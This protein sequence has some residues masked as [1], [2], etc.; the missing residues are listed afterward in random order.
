MAAGHTICWCHG[1]IWRPARAKISM[2]LLDCGQASR[3]VS[4][5]GD[6]ADMIMILKT[7]INYFPSILFTSDTFCT[8]SSAAIFI[9]NRKLWRFS[10]EWC[11]HSAFP[12]FYKPDTVSIHVDLLDY[13][14]TV[15]YRAFL[16]DH[17]QYI[18]IPYIWRRWSDRSWWI[19][20]LYK[21][22]GI[23]PSQFGDEYHSAGAA[24][25][26]G[27]QSWKRCSMAGW[28]SDIIRENIND[29]AVHHVHPQ[30]EAGR[31]AEEASQGKPGQRV[32][33]EKVASWLIWRAAL[34]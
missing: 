7:G 13:S 3:K 28:G 21:N 17:L 29:G 32:K 22:V 18:Y 24:K 27:P 9:F 20:L 30:E 6:N 16:C 31:C 8:R 2:G 14:S 5:A 19:S 1:L 10:T 15:M 33:G 34:N 26:K 4:L 11:H 23:K 12:H 25:A